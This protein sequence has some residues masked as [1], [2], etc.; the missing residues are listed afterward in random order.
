MKEFYFSVL[1]KL[2]SLDIEIKFSIFSPVPTYL[3]LFQLQEILS[4]AVSPV[5]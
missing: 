3:S 2:I 4:E 1:N 5:S